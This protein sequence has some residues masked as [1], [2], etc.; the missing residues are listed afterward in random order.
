MGT[1][2]AAL[3]HERMQT[4]AWTAPKKKQEKMALGDF[5]TDQ[6]TRFPV[7]ELNIIQDGMACSSSP[8]SL[9]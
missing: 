1:V 6:C 3:A 7:V 4:D 2:N 8:S 9:S 5:L